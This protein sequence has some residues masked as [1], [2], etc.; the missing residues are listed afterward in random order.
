MFEVNS[1]IA[2]CQICC[3]HEAHIAVL[4]PLTG[5]L[6]HQLVLV[7]GAAHEIHLNREIKGLGKVQ[8]WTWLHFII[9]MHYLS[10]IIII[11][12]YIHLEILLVPGITDVVRRIRWK[13]VICTWTNMYNQVNAHRV[14][15]YKTQPVNS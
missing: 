15:T 14:V 3:L 10:M 5:P 4:A 13:M 11:N 9:D 8:S 6:Q 7:E 1:N 12:F 2:L